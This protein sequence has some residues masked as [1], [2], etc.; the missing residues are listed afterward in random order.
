MSKIILSNVCVRH[1][2]KLIGLFVFALISLGSG[3]GTPF[4]TIPGKTLSDNESRTGINRGLVLIGRDP[5]LKD[6]EVYAT[7]SS[8]QERKDLTL[9]CKNHQDYISCVNRLSKF[10][11]DANRGKKYYFRNSIAISEEEL[12][13]LRQQHRLMVQQQN[14]ARQEE[15]SRAQHEAE[16]RR[17]ETEVRLQQEAQARIQEAER[18][19]IRNIKPKLNTTD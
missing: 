6:V 1:L 8:E 17:L 14:R 19:R 11:P 7:K 2:F 18:I 12:E 13:K 5:E 15:A 10:L 3:T 4:Q 9:A 16:R